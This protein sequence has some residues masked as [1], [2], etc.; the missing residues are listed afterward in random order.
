MDLR[1]T[2]LGHA[3]V[4]LD[5]GGARI[6]SDPL[7]GRANGPLRRR[8]DVPLREQWEGS[9]AVLI[10]HLHHDHAELS[11]LR[12]LPGVPVLTASENARF[13][14]RKGVPAAVGINSDWYAVPGTDVHVKLTRADHGH[15]PMPHRPNEANG[16]LVRTSSMCVWVA[17]DTSL[18]PEMADLPAQAEGPIDLA[19]V[20]VGGWGARLSG[21]H[22]NGETAAQVCALTGARTAIPYHWGTLYVP[23]TRGHPRGWMDAQAERFSMA[24]PLEAPECKAV[25]LSPGESTDLR[26]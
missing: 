20:P 11:S 4:V 7:L 26:A 15:R 16:H 12:L 25:V 22:L 1:V 5:I 8:G 17:G 13:L 2:W 21:G 14:R 24:M 6:I 3:T 23:G 9:D 19:I 10:S 18:Y